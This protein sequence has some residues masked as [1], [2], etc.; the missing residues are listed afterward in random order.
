MVQTR[1]NKKQNVDNMDYFQVLG[2]VEELKQLEANDKQ[3]EAYNKSKLLVK[4]I[5]DHF[6]KYQPKFRCEVCQVDVPN[7]DLHNKT[8]K[9]KENSGELDDAQKGGI[10]LCEDLKM[11]KNEKPKVITQE[12]DGIKYIITYAPSD[13]LQGNKLVIY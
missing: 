2:I 13:K 8:K 5:T 4:L 10:E 1:K 9:H 12:K 7:I 6:K 11:D 3:L